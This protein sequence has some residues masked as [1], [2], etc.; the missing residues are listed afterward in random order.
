MLE[1]S[2]LTPIQPVQTNGSSSTLGDQTPAALV[3]SIARNGC[4]PPQRLGQLRK[5]RVIFGREHR[6]GR[7]AVAKNLDGSA[8]TE[9]IDRFAVTG[10]CDH[11]AA[12][13]ND[14]GESI[15]R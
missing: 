5:G 7:F 4:A 15:F 13:K 11:L 14:V 8:V 3:P 1:G 9:K 6:V 12:T 2:Q 10:N